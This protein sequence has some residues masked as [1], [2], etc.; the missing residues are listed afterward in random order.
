MFVCPPPPL[1]LPQA[2]RG[3]AGFKEQLAKATD[4]LAVTA[5][6]MPDVLPTEELA[7]R[8]QHEIAFNEK[9]IEL[10]RVEACLAGHL[11]PAEITAEL[12]TA[13]AEHVR[14]LAKLQRE[15]CVDRRRVQQLLCKPALTSLR[16]RRVCVMTETCTPEDT[17]RA[18]VESVADMAHA[19]YIVVEDPAIAD[20]RAIFVSGLTGG[21][22]ITP[23]HLR[24]NGVTGASIAFKPAVKTKR[25]VYFTF[26]FM[27][28][29][30]DLCGNCHT[31]L[32]Q[33][34]CTW[35]LLT[36]EGVYAECAR[37]AAR[38]VRVFVAERDIAEGSLPG[39]THKLTLQRALTHDFVCKLD[40]SRCR[41]GVCLGD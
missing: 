18:G 27:E 41:T 4:A 26:N 34:R 17:R 20:P 3:E 24:S 9:K 36:E 10:A 14:H 7:P 35:V 33:E 40:V 6:A 13:A 32:M 23:Q 2:R 25:W 22:L 29:N 15:R 16:G 28:E 21:A 37:R 8:Q 19:D 12:T 5:G 1:P 38:S 11:A 39:V 30:P 31:V